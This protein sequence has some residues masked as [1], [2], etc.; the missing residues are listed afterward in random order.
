MLVIMPFVFYIGL[1]IYVF[2]SHRFD[3]F[4]EILA[5]IIIIYV[6]ILFGWLYSIGINVC[7]K[8][9]ID[10][11]IGLLKFKLSIFIPVVYLIIIAIFMAVIFPLTGQ[12][13]LPIFVLI[14]PFHFISMAC[15]FYCLHFVAKALKTAEWQQSVSFSDYLGEFFLL[16]F[17]PVGI[18]FIQPRVNKLFSQTTD[19]G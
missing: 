14:I 5:I 18:W 7:K 17:F 2:T 9:P 8:I 1:M 4:F 6:S 3:I 16:C 11:F 13:Q 15:I 10:I 19:N 12:P